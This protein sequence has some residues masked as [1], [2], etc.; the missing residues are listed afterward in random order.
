[1]SPEVHINT[2]RLCS[3]LPPCDRIPWDMIRHLLAGV[4]LGMLPQRGGVSPPGQ[5][6]GEARERNLVLDVMEAGV[7]VT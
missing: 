7:A 3:A 5:A 4:Q 2:G 6:G 1:M